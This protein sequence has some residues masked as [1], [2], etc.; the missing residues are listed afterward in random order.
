V[1][2]GLDGR[3]HLE[4]GPGNDT[5]HAGAGN[6]VV[7]ALS[8]DDRVRGGEGDDYL[9]GGHGRDDIDGGAGRDVLSGGQD[10]DTLDGGA[11]DD[12][13]YSGFGR[14]RVLASAGADTA[15]AQ[16]DDAVD[17]NTHVVTVQLTDVGS[18][19][20]V[21]G[22]PEFVERVQSDLETLRASPTGQLMLG[23]LQLADDASKGWFHGGDGLTITEFTGNN[24]TASDDRDWLFHHHPAIEYSP[25]VDVAGGPPVV[26]L[27]HE[28]AHIYDFVNGT[29]ADGTY[30]DPAHP[31][32]MPDGSGVPNRER[33]AVGLPIDDDGDPS[34]PKRI[35]R[36]HPLQYTENGLREEM[37]VPLRRW[38][39]HG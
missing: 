4:G 34:T 25:T 33:Q 17:A 3:D 9:D 38:Y 26:I 19:I 16:P 31:D 7:Y 27:Y 11:G 29:S 30:Q 6:D 21:E 12:T 23:N 32:L 15:F 24:S 14:D 20:R 5:I 2:L 8:G 18:Y 28:M 13:V 36:L 35:D 1:I 39:G 37:G 10:A 22:S